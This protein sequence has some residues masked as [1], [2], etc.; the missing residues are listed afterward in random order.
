[1]PFPQSLSQRSDETLG[2]CMNCI[3]INTITIRYRPPIPHL[4]DILDELFDATILCKIDLRSGY[5][6]IRWSIGDE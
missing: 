3:P 1:V 2:M 6:Q 5:Q 4:D